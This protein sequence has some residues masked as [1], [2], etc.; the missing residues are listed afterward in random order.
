MQLTERLQ[1]FLIKAPVSNIVQVSDTTMFKI[2]EKAGNKKYIGKQQK[3]TSC[4]NIAPQT[5]FPQLIKISELLLIIW[6]NLMERA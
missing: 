2:V 6:W 5:H 1:I 4:L 3:V